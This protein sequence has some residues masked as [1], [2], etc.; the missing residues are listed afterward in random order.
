MEEKKTEESVKDTPEVKTETHSATVDANPEEDTTLIPATEDA[1]LERSQ[2]PCPAS[3]DAQNEEKITTIVKVHT[4]PATVSLGVTVTPAVDAPMEV[5][6]S[7]DAEEIETAASDASVDPVSPAH[8]HEKPIPPATRTGNPS[9]ASTSPC[10]AANLVP[11][12]ILWAPLTTYKKLIWAIAQKDDNFLPILRIFATSLINLRAPIEFAVMPPFP[13][14]DTP[15]DD[16]EMGDGQQATRIAKEIPQMALVD[17]Q[18]VSKPSN[19]AP[20]AIF[21]SDAA[22]AATSL[23]LSSSLPTDALAATPTP[24]PT[25]STPASTLDNTGQRPHPTGIKIPTPCEIASSNSDILKV[26]ATEDEQLEEAARLTPKEPST[27][28]LQPPP[29]SLVPQEPSILELFQQRLEEPLAPILPDVECKDLPPPRKAKRGV[30][31]HQCHGY[32]H[33]YPE[34]CSVVKNLNCTSRSNAA[35]ST[36]REATSAYST[37]R[38]QPSASTERVSVQDR[39]GRARSQT[40]AESTAKCLRPSPEPLKMNPT[41]DAPRATPSIDDAAAATL[42][43]DAP[44]AKTSTNPSGLPPSP[45]GQMTWPSLPAAPTTAASQDNPSTTSTTAHVVPPGSVRISTRQGRDPITLTTLAPMTTDEWLENI[46]TIDPTALARFLER[47]TPKKP[48]Q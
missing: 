4:P 11:D 35:L 2:T 30:R 39:L 27:T 9:Q 34:C 5:G 41:I 46:V 38:P 21:S 7:P 12:H 26:H 29:T 20:D 24:P 15:Q 1:N 47:Q 18:P 17:P 42:P 25:P 14:L 16:A 28:I 45:S 22:T 6:A 33:G 10:T 32:G 36:N 31:C 40:Y 48:P 3:R 43:T 44:R 13:P 19:P 23:K 37:S 8:P